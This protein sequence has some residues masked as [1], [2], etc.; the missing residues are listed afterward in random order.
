MRFT[1]LALSLA[2]IAPGGETAPSHH[3]AVADALLLRGKVVLVTGSTDGLG[4]EVARA[5]GSLGARGR[6]WM[7]AERAVMNLIVSPQ[8]ESGQYYNGRKPARANAQ[9]Y[10]DAARATLR[11]ISLRLTGEK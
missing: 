3:Q 10:D 7:K 2:A 5:A 6:R 11:E 1:L 9:A 4:R 8:I